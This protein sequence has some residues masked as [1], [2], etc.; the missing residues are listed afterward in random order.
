MKLDIERGC[1][2]GVVWKCFLLQAN[3]NNV[4]NV[5]AVRLEVRG[6]RRK[7]GRK[8]RRRWL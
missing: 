2:M 8:E 3:E 4:V 5:P 6:G 1:G 7:K